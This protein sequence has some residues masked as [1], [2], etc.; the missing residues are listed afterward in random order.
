VKE[1]ALKDINRNWKG[2]IL[3]L[4]ECAPYAYLGGAKKEYVDYCNENK[5]LHKIEM[6]VDRFDAL[7]NN[8][9][10]NGYNPKSMPVLNAKDNVIMDGQH[11]SCYLLK[12]FGPEHRIKALFLEYE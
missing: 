1:I 8:I 12:K 4:N 2:N 9:E 5:Q 7:L 11:R 3:K 10:Q 6:S